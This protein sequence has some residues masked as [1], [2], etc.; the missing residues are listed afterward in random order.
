MDYRTIGFSHNR[1]NP[2]VAMAGVCG[3]AHVTVVMHAN[4]LRKFN[5]CVQKVTRV[6]VDGVCRCGQ[7]PGVV[8][9]VVGGVSIKMLSSL[10]V[11]TVNAKDRGTCCIAT[12][13]LT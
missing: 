11:C 1:P 8:S 7:C 5:Y 6:G 10:S 3:W 9:V 12:A 2:S 4:K 13:M